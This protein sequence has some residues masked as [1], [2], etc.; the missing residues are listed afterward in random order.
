MAAEV[1][2]T[3]TESVRLIFLVQ[4]LARRTAMSSV[5]FLLDLA[6]SMWAVQRWTAFTSQA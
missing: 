3:S 4:R 2:T 1:S 5:T 6:M